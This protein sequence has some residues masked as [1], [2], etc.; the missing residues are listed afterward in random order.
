MKLSMFFTKKGV[1]PK[2]K[3]QEVKD[4]GP[5]LLVI[6]KKHMNG[7]LRIHRQIRILLELSVRLET[8]IDDMD[9]ADWRPSSDK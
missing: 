7:G 4:L 2:G 1:V 5:V 8:I 9:V 3:A 6:W